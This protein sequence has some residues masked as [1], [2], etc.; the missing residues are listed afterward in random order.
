[1]S[2]GAWLSESARRGDAVPTVAEHQRADAPR[3]LP[4]VGLTV[5]VVVYAIAMAYVE[6]AVVVYLRAALEVP[7]DRVF[8]LDLSDAAIGLGSI[9]LGRSAATLCM[10][11]AVGWVIGRSALERLAW[12]AVAFGT[13]DIGY[14]VWLWFFSGW[15]PDLATWDL[16]FLLPL[17]WAG[18]VWAPVV[19][20]IA[21]VGFG[22]AMAGRSQ[23][24]IQPR[25]TRLQLAGL[26]LGGALVIASFLLNAEV[27]VAGGI[28]DAFAWPVFASG[29]AI[30][31]AAAIAVLRSP[32]QGQ[33]AS[34]SPFELSASVDERSTDKDQ[35]DAPAALV[36]DQVDRHLEHMEIGSSDAAKGSTSR[37]HAALAHTADVGVRAMAPDPGGLLEE[38]AA[39]LSELSAEVGRATEVR[40]Q[41]VEARGADLTALTYAWLNDLVGLAEVLGEALVG[42]QVHRVE[43][44]AGGWIARGVATFAAYDGAWVRA[45]VQV[46][47]ATF[48]RLN[49][50]REPEGW[51]IEAYFDV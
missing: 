7:T 40:S 28:P 36:P 20:S 41:P 43:T 16:L 21:L 11:A 49:V 45:K 37:W 30:G 17:P 10:I 32:S 25:A 34:P 23:T 4:P 6:S 24:V 14:Y 33:P 46:K 44:N 1:V 19:V 18:P 35:S 26:L 13:W 5:A 15:P 38:A 51:A 47:A 29:V 48:H 42:A 8:P 27:V 3:L 39:A 50:T 12:A 31:I 22:L 2:V 9:E